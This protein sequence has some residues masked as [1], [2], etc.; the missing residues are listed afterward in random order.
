M[1]AGPGERNNLQREKIEH[2]CRNEEEES[3][4][5]ENYETGDEDQDTDERE[6]LALTGE[7]DIGH[8]I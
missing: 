7:L 1:H 5:D 3:N 6:D 4:E 8:E 2:K